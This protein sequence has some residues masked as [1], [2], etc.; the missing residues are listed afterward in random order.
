MESGLNYGIWIKSWNLSSEALG[1]FLF[2]IGKSMLIGCIDFHKILNRSCVCF[3][4]SYH[5]C[6][7]LI[8]CSHYIIKLP[9]FANCLMN[10]CV[11]E[12]G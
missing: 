8:P 10:S 2:C 9:V 12:W 7:R 11:S 1:S 3:R 5:V 4:R 6:V